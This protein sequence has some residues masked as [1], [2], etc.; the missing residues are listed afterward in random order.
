MTE[1]EQIQEAFEAYFKA[2]GYL[3]SKENRENAFAWFKAGW[4]AMA[5]HNMKEPT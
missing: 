1:E 3:Y 5:E 4:K 2:G